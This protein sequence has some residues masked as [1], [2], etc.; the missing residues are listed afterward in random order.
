VIERIKIPSFPVHF[1]KQDSMKVISLTKHL[2]VS[3]PVFEEVEE[4]PK[5]KPSRSELAA[6]GI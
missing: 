1:E 5:E 2:E 3:V 4:V 6:K